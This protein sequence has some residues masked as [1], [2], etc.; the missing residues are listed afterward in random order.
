MQRDKTLPGS[1]PLGLILSVL[2]LL[3]WTGCSA[4]SE[5]Q[6]EPRPASAETY[7]AADAS[8][9]DASPSDRALSP[10][11]TQP[12]SPPPATTDQ[13]SGASPRFP[14]PPTAAP[15]TAELGS[16]GE[17][18]QAVQPPAAMVYPAPQRSPAA[19]FC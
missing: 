13:P 14:D 9:S 7:P 16:T 2:V 15:P 10:A 4:Q 11:S 18:T 17:A 8:A 3:C 19:F 12:A 1:R 6:V 5:S